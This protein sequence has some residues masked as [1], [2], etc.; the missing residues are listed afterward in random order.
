MAILTIGATIVSLMPLVFTY[1]PWTVQGRMYDRIGPTDVIG[2]GVVHDYKLVF[3]KP[4]LKNRQ[5]GLPNI[6]EAPGGSVFVLVFDLKPKQLETLD[7]F[8]G[9]YEQKSLPVAIG[10]PPVT[11][12]AITWVARRT[13]DGLKPRS[14]LLEMTKTGMEENGAAESFLA[15]V[16][17]YEVL[18]G[19]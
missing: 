17:E 16:T 6:A 14:E 4:N 12:K 19:E 7:G 13:K 9:G 2:A 8:F 1:G 11:R 3:D 18:D 10:E 15:S 5:E